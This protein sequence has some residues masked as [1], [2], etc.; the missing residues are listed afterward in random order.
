MDHLMSRPLLAFLDSFF[1]LSNQIW[2]K[3]RARDVNINSCFFHNRQKNWL[4]F[5]AFCNFPHGKSPLALSCPYIFTDHFEIWQGHFMLCTAQPGGPVVKAFG[6]VQ[7]TPF[8]LA[9]KC[10]M[11]TDQHTAGGSVSQLSQ[12]AN[13][14]PWLALST[15]DI[16]TSFWHYNKSFC[17][18]LTKSRVYHFS[19]PTEYNLCIYGEKLCIYG[20]N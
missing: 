2:Y 11:I 13:L 12:L 15:T 10:L 8:Q 7:K 14:S 4:M 3:G 17:F 6:R 18:Y 9:D 19:N 16:T 1:K 5:F 20:E